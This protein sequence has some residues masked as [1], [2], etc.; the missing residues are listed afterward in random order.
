MP[1]LD[2]SVISEAKQMDL[3]TYLRSYDPQELVHVSG[4]EYTTR[5]HDSLR[6]S[7]NGL[8]N[9][10]SRG[11]G[12]KNALEY[13]IQVKGLNFISAVETIMGRA[14]EVPPTFIPKTQKQPKKLLLPTDTTA[15]S[16]L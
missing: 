11:V 9:W 2:P 15:R 8:W 7:D 1:Y 14:A 16:T 12:G 6:I 13:L 10:C 5:T 4:G 3:L